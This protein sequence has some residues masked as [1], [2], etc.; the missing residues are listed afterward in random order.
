VPP[1][2]EYS[3]AGTEARCSITGGYVVRDP[4]LP[5]LAGRYVYGDFC[6]GRVRTF[7]VSAGSAVEDRPTGLH[8][9]SPSS[10]G[11]DAGGRLYA[12]SLDGQVYRIAAR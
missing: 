5:T 4:S 1:A 9:P 11:E 7:R 6:S 12:L 10:F 2:F 8:I 3:S